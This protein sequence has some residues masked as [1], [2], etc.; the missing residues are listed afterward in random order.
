[1]NT[2]LVLSILILASSVAMMSTDLYAPSLAHLPAFFGT[3]AATVKLSMSLNALAYALGTLVHG[4]LSERF[5]RRPVFLAGLAGFTL[6]SLACGLAQTVGQLIAARILQGLMAAVEGVV[7]LAVIRDVFTDRDQ[8]RAIA[9]YGVA[10]T[11]MPAVAPILGGYIFI[12]FGWRMNFYFLAVVAMFTTLL[13]FRYL[14]ESGRRDFDVLRVREMLGDYLGLLHNRDFLRYTLI[15]GS[16]VAFFFGFITAGPFILIQQ[17]GL[18]TQYFGYFQGLLVLAYGVGSVLTGRLARR[19]PTDRLMLLGMV[20]AVGGGIALFVI[21]YGGYETPATLAVVLAAMAFA[22]GPI[23]ATTPAL[24]MNAGR[25]RTGHAAALLLTI[26]VGMGSLAALAVG[27][28]HDGT[29]R[30]F[31]LTS[32]FF[33]LVAVVAWLSGKGSEKWKVKSAKQDRGHTGA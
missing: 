7:V 31:A 9:I 12:W 29:T 28:F 22:D 25:G 16:T 33:C 19:W 14:P 1:V 3:D 26:E 5:G 6:F 4:P 18:P 20:P 15:G 17:H 23:F 24:A 21:V 8:V 2:K 32:G 27:V 30:P 10:T 13:I 11:M